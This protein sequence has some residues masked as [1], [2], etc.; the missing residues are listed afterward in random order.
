MNQ[1]LP[2]VCP[3][4]TQP[5]RAYKL[6]K[7]RWSYNPV[8]LRISRPDGTAA[9]GAGVMQATHAQPA[10]SD[11]AAAQASGVVPAEPCRGQSGPTQSD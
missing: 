3:P 10:G 7:R 5:R 4:H 9:P 1:P 6:G 8:E 2:T 11:A